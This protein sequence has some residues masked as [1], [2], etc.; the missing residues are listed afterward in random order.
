MN[1]NSEI[2][3]LLGETF[4]N[5]TIVVDGDGYHYKVNII[6]DQF[7]GLSKVKRQQL[8]YRVLQELITEGK[9]HAI[10]IYA[11]TIS[12]SGAKG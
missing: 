3:H 11:L 6:S 1:A 8:V 4:K 9:L 5:S 12:E 2:E 7:E 10:T